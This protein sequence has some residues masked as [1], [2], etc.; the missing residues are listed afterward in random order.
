MVVI[1]TTL[2]GLPTSAISPV[3]PIGPVEGAAV[4]DAWPVAAG[5]IDAFSVEAG[6]QSGPHTNL[7]IS[8]SLLRLLG[9]GSEPATFHGVPVIKNRLPGAVSL[10][11]ADVPRHLLDLDAC[12][13][14]VI[15][16]LPPEE[17]GQNEMMRSYY[18]ARSECVNESF[19]GLPPETQRLRVKNHF[20]RKLAAVSERAG[21]LFAIT[22]SFIRSTPDV[23]VDQI[24]EFA[25]AREFKELPADVRRDF[26]V[27]ILRFDNNRS[28]IQLVL[29][30]FEPDELFRVVFGF[31]PMGEVTLDSRT[32][33]CIH[34]ICDPRDFYRIM[35]SDARTLSPAKLKA[36]MK[37][38]PIKSSGCNFRSIKGLPPLDGMINA[39]PRPANDPREWCNYDGTFRHEERH[40]IQ[41]RLLLFGRRH[42]QAMDVA[43]NIDVRA[44]ELRA[45]V[46][47][48]IRDSVSSFRD[49]T[50]PGSRVAEFMKN[51]EEAWQ[52]RARDELVAY[53]SV[54]G[55]TDEEIAAISH[56]ISGYDYPSESRGYMLETLPPE[57]KYSMAYDAITEEYH[58]AITRM[59]FIAEVVLGRVREPEARKDL[60]ARFGVTPVRRW[61][62]VFQGYLEEARKE[63]SIEDE[64]VKLRGA[65][66][67]IGNLISE[68]EKS[69]RRPFEIYLWARW[70]NRE[71]IR[72][73][74]FRDHDVQRLL[75]ES[76]IED[77]MVYSFRFAV[78]RHNQT[79]S[80]NIHDGLRDFVSVAPNHIF[81]ERLKRKFLKACD[82]FMSFADHLK[83]GLIIGG[84]TKNAL[85]RFFNPRGAEALPPAS[86]WILSSEVDDA[87]W[88]F[89]TVLALLDTGRFVEF[90]HGRGELFEF[91]NRETGLETVYIKAF[92]NDKI[93]LAGVDPIFLCLYT[94]V[95]D[96]C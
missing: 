59:A 11:P 48:D 86:R 41:N 14:T 9:I 84:V 93:A 39:S 52:I 82:G 5:E 45:A 26:K 32:Q 78:I 92:L 66:S 19:S 21:R 2:L 63:V 25:N 61:D 88:S 74:Y 17:P 67:A 34:F 27:G 50:A 69:R 60:I 18:E 91:L 68:D 6:A 22:E 44:L 55:G 83:A 96:E 28:K 89:C 40:A 87:L 3:V 64:F 10:K 53:L 80:H 38:R 56:V 33:F 13:E 24:L 58:A 31:A 42:E 70:I 79:S 73:L 57:P 4:M 37:E 95:E 62:K 71:L 76:G 7:S 46:D 15:R 51:L 36:R 85:S 77:Q 8:H 54:Y 30:Q 94:R 12:L 35:V 20:H 72:S 47:A 29:Q 65:L 75:D 23:T 49:Q 1:E 43:L 81:G 90:Y 16:S